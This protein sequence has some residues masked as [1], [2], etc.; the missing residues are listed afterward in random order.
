MPARLGSSSFVAWSLLEIPRI[1]GLHRHRSLPRLTRIHCRGDHNG[2]VQTYF[3][4]KLMV[5]DDHIDVGRSRWKIDAVF[6]DPGAY[7]QL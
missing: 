2:C 6:S 4:F 5:V 3:Y 7:F 1:V